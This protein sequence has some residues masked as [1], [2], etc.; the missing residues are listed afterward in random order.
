MVGFFILANHGNNMPIIININSTL[1]FPK[2]KMKEINNAI[3]NAD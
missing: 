1:A 3:N 2:I